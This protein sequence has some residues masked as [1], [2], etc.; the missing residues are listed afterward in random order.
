MSAEKLSSSGIAQTLRS[1]RTL[2]D[3]ERI[4]LWIA[5]GVPDAEIL[6]RMKKNWRSEVITLAGK[7]HC[8]DC[9]QPISFF[10]LP[11][12]RTTR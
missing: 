6:K 2:K 7:L 12:V 1:P 10:S 8:A 4:R 9:L 11:G 5:E 3:D